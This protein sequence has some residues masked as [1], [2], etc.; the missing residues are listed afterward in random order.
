MGEKTVRVVAAIIMKDDQYLITRRRP[1]AV[2]PLLW[3]FPGGRVE[4]GEDDADALKKGNPEAY[5]LYRKL[6][7]ER[8]RRIRTRIFREAEGEYAQR[9]KEW[10]D[11]FRAWRERFGQGRD[12]F[13]ADRDRPEG[14]PETHERPARHR[15]GAASFSVDASGRISVTVREADS[16]ITLEFEN[17]GELKQ[18]FPKLFERFERMQERLK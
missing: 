4:E 13:R 12:R 15:R 1:K 10:K 9:L 8:E 2:L 18:K 7:V 5:E 17:E 11:A 16:D 3:E 14:A 6:N